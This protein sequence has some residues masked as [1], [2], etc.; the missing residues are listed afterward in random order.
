[1]EGLAPEHPEPRIPE[2]GP[3]TNIPAIRER[4][5]LVLGNGVYLVVA[6]NRE[7]K[8][9]N[10]ISTDGPRYLLEKIPFS[11][12]KRLDV[13]GEVS[14]AFSENFRRSNLFDRIS[15]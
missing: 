13:S 12:L 15:L 10:L 4:V 8:N 7:L 1:M 3:T 2:I 5:G 9:V 11:A 14:G 6:V